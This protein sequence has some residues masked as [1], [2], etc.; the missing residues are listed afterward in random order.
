L[1]MMDEP[2]QR[3]A[4]ADIANL[5]GPSDALDL[6][7]LR[8]RAAGGAAS[9]GVRSAFTLALAVGGNIAL[10]LLLNPRDFGLVA[11]GTTLLLAGNFIA[12]GGLG[13]ALVGR[14]KAPT[15]YEL[16]AITG[17]QLAVSCTLAVLFAAAAWP[18]GTDGLVPAIM[19]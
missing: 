10:A 12:A 2:G 14:P 8:R 1:D 3:P 7:E 6:D 19:V 13:V 18:F 16:E 9:L 11:L 4:D 15:R 17:L 5:V